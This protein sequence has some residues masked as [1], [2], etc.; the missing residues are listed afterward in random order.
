[1]LSAAIFVAG[2]TKPLPDHPALAKTDEQ[3]LIIAHRGGDG[4]RPANTMEAFRAALNAGANVLA[5]D[6]HA[7]HDGVLV[8]IHDE[9]L[10]R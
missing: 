1:M 7:S 10:D 9:T 5:F 2:C 8:A 4:L 6:V 3:P